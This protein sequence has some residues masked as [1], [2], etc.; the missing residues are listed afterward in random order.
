MKVIIVEPLAQSNNITDNSLLKRVQ[1][2]SVYTLADTSLLTHGKPMFVPDYGGSCKACCCVAARIC[3]LGKSI[4]ERFAPRYFDALTVGMRFEL[5][6]LRNELSLKG[7]PWDVAVSFDGSAVIGRFV[8]TGDTPADNYNIS[9]EVE[10]EKVASVQFT[11][12]IPAVAHAVAY[13]SRY[14]M[15]RQGDVLLLPVYGKMLDTRPDT[16]YVGYINGD[17]VLEFNVK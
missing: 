1:D 10:G 12:L 9:L 5:N 13:V 3:R 6:D 2:M 7:L 15:I 11:D 4:P 17:D 8:E 16:H 14:Y